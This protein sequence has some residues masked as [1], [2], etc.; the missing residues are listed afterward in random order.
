[1]LNTNTKVL[2]F[3][4]NEHIRKKVDGPYFEKSLIS[5][6]VMTLQRKPEENMLQFCEFQ[7]S[8]QFKV[9]FIWFTR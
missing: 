9:K 5:D 2:S 1:M 3:K 8:S 6:P 7:I 4:S